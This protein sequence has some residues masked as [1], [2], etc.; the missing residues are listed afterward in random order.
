MTLLYDVLGASGALIFALVTAW[1]SGWLWRDS[2]R[3]PAAVA[4]MP[5]FWLILGLVGVMLK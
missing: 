2:E 4:A 3:W 5:A 1:A